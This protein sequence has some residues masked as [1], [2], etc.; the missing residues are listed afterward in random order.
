M[1]FDYKMAMKNMGSD[2]QG[3]YRI[4]CLH[5]ITIYAPVNLRARA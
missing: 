3:V 5:D 4:V 2:S 1:E